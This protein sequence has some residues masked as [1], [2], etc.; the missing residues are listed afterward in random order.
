[1]NA[2]LVAGELH[3]GAAEPGVLVQ[4]SARR[5]EQGRLPESCLAIG[6]LLQPAPGALEDGSY[7]HELK[8]LW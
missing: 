8:C 1:L 5:D 6:G 3:G 7:G 2:R 4:Q